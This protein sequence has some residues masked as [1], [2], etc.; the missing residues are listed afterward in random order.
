MVLAAGHPSRPDAAAALANLCRAY[1]YPIYGYVRRRTADVHRAQDLTQDFFV[2]LLEREVVAVA[3]PE[4]GR[5]R[6]FLLTTLKNFLASEHE[7]R[8][9]EKRGGGQ[10]VLPLDF[11]VGESRLSLEPVDDWTPERLFERQ[12]A[13][14]LL[15]HVMT[16]LQGECA[17]AGKEAQFEQLKGLLAGR[18]AEMPVAE[19]A[20]AL[21][22]TEEATRQAVHRLR[23]RYREL[24]RSEVAQTVAGPEEV[25]DE[26]KRLFAALGS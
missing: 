5:F 26:L 2:K 10:A 7:R 8:T 23:G 21:G 16:R 20:A 6:N 12:W 4:R 1:W 9:A 13:I 14:T 11:A 3:Q 25:D 18:S 19:A 17:A 15:G 22:L 24:L